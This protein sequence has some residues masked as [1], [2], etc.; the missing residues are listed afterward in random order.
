MLSFWWSLLIF[1]CIC[2]RFHSSG[3]FDRT[4]QVLSWPRVLATF[5]GHSAMGLNTDSPV[6]VTQN[7]SLATALW[8]TLENHSVHLMKHH[9]HWVLLLNNCNQTA[10]QTWTAQRQDYSWRDPKLN[11]LLING[12]W[13]LSLTP[14]CSRLI[15][16]LTMSW[17]IPMKEKLAPYRIR[18]TWLLD[19]MPD[20]NTLS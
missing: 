17:I 9:W 19:F 18:T 11:S 5:Y 10:C 7:D 4:C 12:C 2:T 20:T 8:S 16:K 3:S 1:A 13:T 6:K 15:V 14:R